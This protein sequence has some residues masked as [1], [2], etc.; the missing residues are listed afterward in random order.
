MNIEPTTATDYKIKAINCVRDT[1]LPI[2]KGQFVECGCNLDEQ[3]RKYGNTPWFFAE[4]IEP[5]HIYEIGYPKC[6]CP[7]VLKG[8]TKEKSHCECSR[9]SI[10]YILSTLMPDKKITV[11]TIGTVLSGADKC[12][13]RVV[14]E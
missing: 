5:G 6:V 1:V 10:I 13:F 3:Y 11:E 2:Q 12:R 7:E 8:L 9:Q 14:V 4:I